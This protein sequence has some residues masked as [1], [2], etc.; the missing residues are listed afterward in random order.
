MKTKDDVQHLQPALSCFHSEYLIRALHHVASLAVAETIIPD[1]VLHTATFFLKPRP[2]SEDGRPCVH[3]SNISAPTWAAQRKMTLINRIFNLQIHMTPLCKLLIQVI[4]QEFSMGN[5]QARIVARLRDAD[6]SVR[7]S[8]CETLGKL[9]ADEIVKLKDRILPLLEDI[10]KFVRSSACETLGNLPADELVKLRDHIVPL[11]KDTDW[12][13]RKSACETLGKLPADEIVKLKDHFVPLLKHTDWFVRA[14]ACETLGQLPVDELVK[15][16]DHIV[17]LLK[18]TDLFVRARAFALF[19]K[20]EL[21]KDLISLVEKSRPALLLHFAARAGDWPAC[22]LLVRCGFSLEEKDSD[23]KTPSEIARRFRHLDLA[24]RLKSDFLHTK[25]GN[26][27]AIARA[28]QDDNQI[29]AVSW[30][31]MPLSGWARRFG[32]QHSVLVVKVKHF[33]YAIERAR[34][35]QYDLVSQKLEIKQ[36]TKKG[37][38]VSDWE[39]VKIVP[40]LV[41]LEE[42]T[43]LKGA[44][45]KLGT[46]PSSLVTYLFSFDGYDVGRNNC[47]H[48]A[49]EAFNFCTESRQ[50]TSLPVNLWQSFAAKVVQFLGS[51]LANGRSASGTCAS[52]PLYDDVIRHPL[53]TGSKPTEWSS[54]GQKKEYLQEVGR[55]SAQYQKVKDFVMKFGGNET[56]IPGFKIE[57]IYR[58]ENFGS[59]KKYV[60]H[61]EDKTAQH[62]YCWLLHGPGGQQG[63]QKIV[64]EGRGF[65]DD[66]RSMTF[67]AYGQGH[68]FALDFRLA[69]FFAEGKSQHEPK[70]TR[71]VL[72][73]RVAAGKP[74]DAER[75]FP[76]VPGDPKSGRTDADWTRKME[77][78]NKSKPERH[79]NSWIGDDRALIVGKGEMVYVD[80]V[81]EY[82]STKLAGNPY[83]DPLMK[84]IRKL[85][86]PSF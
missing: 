35:V 13:V 33:A 28:L 22:V 68:Y 11:L 59:Y 40:H 12:S 16:E 30:Y 62:E 25:G 17:L 31:T 51:D 42:V 20:L 34:S 81:V 75:L 77:E 7:K 23:G 45:I 80:Y 55:G 76:Y 4:F 52:E 56:E 15:L 5:S 29:E 27:M 39:E 60:Q 24:E 74:F 84:E 61:L 2:K 63:Y 67:A 8:A 19:G 49:M 57:K 10:S 65:D 44:D 9:P 85:P 70:K 32:G 41:R 83:L 1:T 21:T 64:E 36:A 54:D 79:D 69:D 43:P 38:F 6:W 50:M 3:S 18:D 47:H 71:R 78:F 66:F 37:L 82:T 73:C 72:L 48:T 46:S 53:I 26:G 58:N 14:S 86:R